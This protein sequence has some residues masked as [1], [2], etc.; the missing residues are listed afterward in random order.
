[1]I[2]QEAILASMNKNSILQIGIEIDTI[3]NAILAL[4]EA[5]WHSRAS[6]NELGEKELLKCREPLRS[7]MLWAI[8]LD[9]GQI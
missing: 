5:I 3:K 1:M 2:G 9:R 7:A 6:G 8:D 4:E